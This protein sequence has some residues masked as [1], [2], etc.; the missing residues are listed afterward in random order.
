V[1]GNEKPK[2]DTQ[3]EA[4][5]TIR[6]NLAAIGI[7]TLLV[8]F[9]VASAG[10]FQINPKCAVMNDRHDKIGCTCALQNGGWVRPVHGQWRWNYNTF[11][12]DKVHQCIQ[13]AK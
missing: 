3:R 8:I 9:M 6:K 1:R 13:S 4:V 10:A 7:G 11:H 2:V 12:M 5:M